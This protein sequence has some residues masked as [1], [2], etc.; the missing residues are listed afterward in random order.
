MPVGR[1]NFTWTRQ[2]SPQYT[3]ATTCYTLTINTT[4][5]MLH[6]ERT[7]DNHT[8]SWTDPIARAA[9]AP[10]G[11]GNA[12][13]DDCW[14]QQPDACC[15]GIRW[16]GDDLTKHLELRSLGMNDNHGIKEHKDDTQLW[17]S[18]QITKVGKLT[19]CRIATH[20][21]TM[22]EKLSFN[23]MWHNT[24]SPSDISNWGT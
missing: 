23:L 17:C 8:S 21:H 20:H 7:Y 5:H 14:S 13:V 11:I 1:N 12:E 6:G 24:L 2:S 9:L 16:I 19:I 3:P 22:Q 4:K 15:P 18:S 10:H